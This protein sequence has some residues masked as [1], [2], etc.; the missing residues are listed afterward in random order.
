MQNKHGRF[1]AR[2]VT[3]HC[4]FIESL[5]S[6]LILFILNFLNLH[7][8][9]EFLLNLPRFIP[10]TPYVFQRPH[11]RANSQ[12]PAPPKKAGSEP[13]LQEH[14]YGQNFK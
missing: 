13:I 6:V 12:L 11:L 1:E 3:V 5:K 2:E 9:P 10:V 14:H 7:S 4:Y 8:F